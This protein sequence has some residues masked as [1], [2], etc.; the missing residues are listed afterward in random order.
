MQDVIGQ[1]IKLGD[2]AIL[3]NK[4]DAFCVSSFLV[5]SK[6]GNKNN[7]QITRVYTDDTN[8]DWAPFQSYVDVSS[9]VVI[10]EQVRHS[11]GTEFVEKIQSKV[12]VSN[13]TPKPAKEKREYAFVKFNEE[14]YVICSVGIIQYDIR[15]NRAISIKEIVGNDYVYPEGL[16]RMKKEMGSFTFSKYAYDCHIFGYNTVK[17]IQGC[18]FKENGFRKLDNFDINQLIKG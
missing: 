6:F 10:T 15:K 8:R 3:S 18:D 16:F 13:E 14:V 2:I 4:S 12:Q 11:F 5:I 17:N 1:E 7:V 9:V